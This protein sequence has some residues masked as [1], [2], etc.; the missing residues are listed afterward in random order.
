[1]YLKNEGVTLKIR[2]FVKLQWQVKPCFNSSF[3]TVTMAT[4]TILRVMSKISLT[5]F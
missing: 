5:D 3:M 2:R 1:M 4:K